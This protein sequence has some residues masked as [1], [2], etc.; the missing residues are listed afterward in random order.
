MDQE[1]EIMNAY[2]VIFDQLSQLGPGDSEITRSLVERL[3]SDLPRA[4][5]VADF[6][7]GVGASSLVLAQSLPEARIL[8]V[9]MHEP[10]IERLK[11]EASNL[12]L[13]DRINA[14]VG[15]MASPPPLDEIAGNFDLIWSESA[16]YNI[17]RGKAFATWL[18][19]LN[20]DGWLVFSDIVWQY[21]STARSGKVS[22]FWL[23]EYPDITTAAAVVNELETA[24]FKPL[25]PVLSDRKAWSNYYEPL[26]ERVRLLTKRDDQ[27][28][29]L[30]TVIAEIEREIEIYDAAENE[31]ALTFFLARRD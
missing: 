24:G 26:R 14:A 23:N 10:F 22:T 15:D 13:A 18:P 12:G 31:V 8:A 29:A 5:R 25:E 11:T 20:P 4:P 21:E 7:C 3:R 30:N 17:G 1:Q 19:L 16:I 2:T 28:Q 6:G 27:P 9:D